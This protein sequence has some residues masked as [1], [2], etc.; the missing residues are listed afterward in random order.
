L[1][2]SFWQRLVRNSQFAG[3]LLPATSVIILEQVFLPKQNLRALS[4]AG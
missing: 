1:V 3:S 4:S 2:R